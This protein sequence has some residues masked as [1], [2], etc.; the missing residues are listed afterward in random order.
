VLILKNKFFYTISGVYSSL[1]LHRLLSRKFLKQLAS[2]LNNAIIIVLLL[3]QTEVAD[4]TLT[5]M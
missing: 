2:E 5:K 1:L 3:M 4:I